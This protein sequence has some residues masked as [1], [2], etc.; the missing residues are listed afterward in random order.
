MENCFLPFAPYIFVEN[1]S[2]YPVL[3]Y[4]LTAGA[5]VAGTSSK[6]KGPLR[7]HFSAATQPFLLLLVCVRFFMICWLLL[8]D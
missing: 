6:E 3:K 1:R 2:P 5:R 8:I 4:S 7:F